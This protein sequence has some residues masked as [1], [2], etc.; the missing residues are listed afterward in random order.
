MRT[1]IQIFKDAADAVGIENFD[2]G[3]RSYENLKG[4]ETPRLF[5]HDVIIRDQM[6]ATGKAS[7]VYL[8]TFDLNKT[9]PFAANFEQVEAAFELLSPLWYSFLNKLVQDPRLLEKPE[10]VERVEIIHEFD[11]NACGWLCSLEMKIK[12]DLGVVC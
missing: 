9:V 4:V 12:E 7:P 8:V 11:Q 6:K 2:R 1:V 5:I 10:N 3:V